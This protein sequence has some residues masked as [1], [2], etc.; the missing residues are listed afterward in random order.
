M[1]YA[2][3]LLCKLLSSTLEIWWSWSFLWKSSGSSR[4]MLCYSIY[5]DKVTTVMLSKSQSNINAQSH[6]FDG[7]HKNA[8][9]WL[10]LPIV[11]GISLTCWGVSWWTLLAYSLISSKG[12]SCITSFLREWGKGEGEACLGLGSFNR[13]CGSP[14]VSTGSSLKSLIW[15]NIWKN[16]DDILGWLRQGTWKTSAK[17]TVRGSDLPVTGSLLYSSSSIPCEAVKS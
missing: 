6:L 17:K 4:D 14:S 3:A 15:R 10:Q 12:C 1:Q 11:F 9:V 16:S 8:E 7:E 2:T 5:A 13:K